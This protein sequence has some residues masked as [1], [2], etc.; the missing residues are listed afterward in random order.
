MSRAAEYSD[1]DSDWV[2]WT[3]RNVGGFASTGQ[4]PGSSS[5]HHT[6]LPSR[7]PSPSPPPPPKF[8]SCDA[9]FSFTAGDS[10]DGRWRIAVFVVQ[11]GGGAAEEYPEV[12]EAADTYGSGGGGGATVTVT[13]DSLWPETGS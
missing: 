3:Q 7:W 11:T 13:R 4:L 6:S 2:K 8:P 12:V 5:S 10:M 1:F 9:R